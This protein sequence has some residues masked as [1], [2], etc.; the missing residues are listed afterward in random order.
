MKYQQQ[1]EAE[2]DWLGWEEVLFNNNN[3]K[4]KYCPG[5]KYHKKERAIDLVERI[6]HLSSCQTDEQAHTPPIVGGQMHDK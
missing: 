6:W 3:K 5:I 4:T 1:G 2:G